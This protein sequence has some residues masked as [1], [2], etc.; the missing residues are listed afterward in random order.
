M[1]LDRPR[2]Y[3]EWKESA[4]QRQGEY[5]H[6]KNRKEQVKGVPP[7]LYNPFTP[8]SNTHTPQRDPDAMDVD[9]GR[10]RLAGAEDVLYNDAYKREIQRRTEEEDRRLGIDDASKPPFKLREGYHQRQREM[11]KGG[12]TKVTCYNCNQQGHISRYCPQKRKDKARARAVQEG[13]A[14]QTALERANTWLRGVGGEDDEVKNLILQ[15]MGKDE[16]FPSA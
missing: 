7:C 10:A 2:T 1:R 13:P 11:R 6:F 3:E 14:E 8:R 15:T 16:D 5:I 4:I 9:R 12:L